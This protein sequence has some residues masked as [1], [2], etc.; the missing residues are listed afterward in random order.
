MP[1][2]LEVLLNL[3]P[4]YASE[5]FVLVCTYDAASRA[6]TIGNT[7]DLV[8]YVLGFAVFHDLT[9][10]AERCPDLMLDKNV[11]Y[12]YQQ[13]F[14]C[15]DYDIRIKLGAYD[16]VKLLNTYDCPLRFVPTGSIVPKRYILAQKL[17]DFEYWAHQQERVLQPDIR[18]HFVHNIAM[19][20]MLP[21]E[22]QI[23]P[24]VFHGNY[25]CHM[26]PI[27]DSAMHRIATK[28]ATCKKVKAPDDLLLKMMYEVGRITSK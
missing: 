25:G 3:F 19:G 4:E 6:K 7:M 16:G 8:K 15:D 22:K 21:P 10:Y 17:S 26:D 18:R 1:S 13:E 5:M 28:L 9:I 27:S 2:K 11:K 14:L 24:K 20:D 23:K 12:L